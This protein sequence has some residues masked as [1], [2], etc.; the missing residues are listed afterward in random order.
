MDMIKLTKD[1]HETGYLYADV[2]FEVGDSDASNDFEI[3]T[4]EGIQGLYIPGTEWGGLVEYVELSNTSAEKTYK[5]WTWRG[6]LSQRIIIPPSG[7]DYKTVSGDANNIIRQLIGT[8]FGTLIRVPT[9]SSGITITNHQFT[10]YETLLD[11]LTEML[12]EVGAKLYIHAEK[13]APGKPIV[14][15]VEAVTATTLEATYTDESPVTLAVKSDGMGINHLYACGKGDLQARKRMDLYLDN[16]GLVSTT[17]YYTGI[18]ERVEYYDANN[19][20]DDE[21]YKYGEKRLLERASSTTIEIKAD[22]SAD[23]EVGD[24]VKG[25]LNGVEIFAPVKKKVYKIADGVAEAEYTVGDYSTTAEAKKYTYSVI[26]DSYSAYQGD[27]SPSGNAKYY[28][29]GDVTDKSMMWYRLV[30]SAHGLTLKQNNSYG[31]SRISKSTDD[32]STSFIERAENLLDADYIFIEGGLNDCWGSVTLGKAIYSDWDDDS[33]KQFLP[34]LCYL[35]DYMQ[36]N[37]DGTLIFVMMADGLT[38]EY[39]SGIKSV[40]SH[41]GVLYAECT[42]YSQ[43]NKHPTAAG[44]QTISTTINELF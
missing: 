36:S 12:E 9:K 11:G 5:G 39:I 4:P 23:L 14:V 35:F 24:I 2:D 42:S 15:Y 37:M 28:P 30:G 38:T 31:G 25:Y 8:S 44:M 43:S 17:K 1:Y 26:G 3:T 10:L 29:T 27:Y 22:S 40:C 16:K 13:E 7:S 41:Y 20:E 6:L 19:I 34:S 18:Q 33:L 32:T 21:L